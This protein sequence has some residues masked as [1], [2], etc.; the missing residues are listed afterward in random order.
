MGKRRKTTSRIGFSLKNGI[1]SVYSVTSQYASKSAPIRERFF[2]IDE[3]A[4]A[5]LDVQ[6]YVDTI[7][8]FDIPVSLL[9]NQTPIG[10]LS[11]ADKQNFIEFLS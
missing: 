7:S 1:A 3:W 9:K 4:S 11:E 5:G 6:S 8:Y 2:K 10:K